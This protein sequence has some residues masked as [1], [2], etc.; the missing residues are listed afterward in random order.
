M[1]AIIIIIKT[2]FP[3]S[4]RSQHSLWLEQELIKY[5]RMLGLFHVWNSLRQ[6]P[7]SPP[8]S[9]NPGEMPLPAAS[10]LCPPGAV[11]SLKHNCMCVSPKSSIGT[12][13][14][15]CL[16]NT[17]TVPGTE[18]TLGLKYLTG[19]SLTVQWLRLHAPN[20]GGPGFYPWSG[21]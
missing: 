19:T 1:V 16:I 12:R 21:N 5:W 11:W 18:Q 17:F 8:P 3:L 4:Y 9:P 13:T 10:T 7:S 14:T 6:Q 2:M 15:L 20:A